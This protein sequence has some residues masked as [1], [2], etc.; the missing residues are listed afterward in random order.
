M[1]LP[2][3]TGPDLTREDSP[4]LSPPPDVTDNRQCALCLKYGDDNTNVSVCP[5]P[6]HLLTPFCSASIHLLS[7]MGRYGVILQW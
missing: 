2:P 6:S 3:P 1:P 4:E 5:P 7:H